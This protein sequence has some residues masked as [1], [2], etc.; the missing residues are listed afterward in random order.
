MYFW[1]RSEMQAQNRPVMVETKVEREWS[2][3]EAETRD[4]QEIE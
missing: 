1:S 3:G 4:F 2:C